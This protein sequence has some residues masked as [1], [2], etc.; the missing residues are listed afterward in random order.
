MIFTI[1]FIIEYSYFSPDINKQKTICV[2]LYYFVQKLITP[3]SSKIPK[4]RIN[5]LIEFGMPLVCSYLVT[6]TAKTVYR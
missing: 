4:E 3:F 1:R 5:E 2:S 6:F